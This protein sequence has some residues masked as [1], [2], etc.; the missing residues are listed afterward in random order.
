MHYATL[1]SPT[2]RPR[3]FPCTDSGL[4]LALR[5]ALLQSEARSVADGGALRTVAAWLAER[6]PLDDGRL[7]AP[8]LVRFVLAEVTEALD[9]EE[10]PHRRSRIGLAQAVAELRTTLRL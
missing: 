1:D 6:A 10:G 9:R 2:S 5:L 8:G 3:S 4:R 7:V